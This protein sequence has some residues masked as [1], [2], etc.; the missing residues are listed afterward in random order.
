MRLLHTSTLKLHEFFGDQIPSYAILSHTWGNEEVTLQDLE[1]EESKN[2]AGYAKIT[3]CCALAL[4]TG[5]EWVWIDTCCIDKTSSAELSKA[6]N[7]MYRWYRD[8][9]VCYAYLTDCFLPLGKISDVDFCKSRW[10]SRGWTLQELLAPGTVIFYDRNWREIGTKSSLTPQI[11]FVTGISS[12]DMADPQSASIAAKMS[13]A[14]RRQ[15]SRVEDM[16]YSL[17][18]IFDLTMPLLYGEGHNAFRRL[19]YEL[20]VARS[21]DESI[22]AWTHDGP[23]PSGM[24]APSPAAF[25]DS[26]DV[27]T[28][29]NLYPLTRPP[30][31]MGKLLVMNGMSPVR[32]P[33][34]DVKTSMVILN[35]A[36]QANINEPLGIRLVPGVQGYYMEADPGTLLECESP[37]H[38]KQPTRPG[39]YN[40]S[41]EIWLTRPYAIKVSNFT[42]HR[43]HVHLPLLKQGF[44]LSDEFLSDCGRLWRYN[45]CWQATFSSTG[46]VGVMM[47]IGGTGENFLLIL[48]VRD[49]LPSVDVV[50]PHEMQTPSLEE[51]TTRYRDVHYGNI[52]GADELF[53]PLQGKNHVFVT[54]RKKLLKGKGVNVVDVSIR[55]EKMTSIV[56]IAREEKDR[57]PQNPGRLSR[58]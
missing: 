26:G 34:E 15:T 53:K 22:F 17:L 24:L 2:R 12:Q 46:D 27:I 6:I 51:I 37:R 55:Q 8:S 49:N 56:V 11:S 1:K 19:Q 48:A 29:V 52:R 43:F 54:L 3:G 35:C 50:V 32:G 14:S 25:A 33:T 38:T 40:N 13:W 45:G 18:G 21:D 30:S 44:R 57:N 20:I 58:L 4:S 42:P 9:E 47:F 5:W 31:V 41:L 28:F 7:S 36:R 16:A 39:F 23:R 10:F